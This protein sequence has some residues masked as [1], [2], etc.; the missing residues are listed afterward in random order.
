MY[1]IREYKKDDKEQVIKLW[2]DVAVEEYGY[3]DWEEEI[4]ILDENEY[5]KILVALSEG[6]IIGSMAYKKAE[7]DIAELKRVYLYKEF[8]GMGIA[9]QLYNKVMDIIKQEGY[10]KIMVET[11]EKLPSGI[12]FYIKNDFKLITKEDRGED[13]RYVFMLNID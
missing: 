1:E 8:R 9:K 13:K 3:K 10:K 4:K 12:N 11:W 2:V 5:E 6:K 7:K